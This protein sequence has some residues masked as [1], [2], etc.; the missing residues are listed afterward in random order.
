MRRVVFG[1]RHDDA[2]ICRSDVQLFAVPVIAGELDDQ[3]AIG[4]A[5]MHAAADASQDHA[6]IDAIEFDP[7]IY[8][9]DRD[10]AVVC[11]ERKIG[12]A[13]HKNLETYRPIKITT[14]LWSSGVNP[15]TACFDKDLLCQF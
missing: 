7:A 6:T 14:L 3:S 15:L 8:L 13:R 1:H 10:A 2:A 11:L 4:G 9:R 12:S 5:A